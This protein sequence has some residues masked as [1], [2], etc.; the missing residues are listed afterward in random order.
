MSI[1]DNWLKIEIEDTGLGI[2]EAD[3]KHLFKVFGQVKNDQG[4]NK[5][6]VGLG[7][8]ILN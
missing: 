7:L 4:L 6:G 5:N 1:K 8:V 3:Q 2:K